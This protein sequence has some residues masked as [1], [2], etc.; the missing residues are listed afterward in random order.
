MGCEMPPRACDE[1]PL[2]S[3]L[4]VVIQSVSPVQCLKGHM[5][6]SLRLPGLYNSSWQARRERAWLQLRWFSP[7]CLEASVMDT[8]M[9]AEREV[10][11]EARGPVARE[12]LKSVSTNPLRPA[13]T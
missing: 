2:S 11:P 12:V 9:R 6:H 8:C 10:V 4:L 7:R 5:P 1:L 3:G 13:A